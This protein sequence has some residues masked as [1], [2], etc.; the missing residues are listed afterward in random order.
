MTMGLE[1]STEKQR[2]HCQ[3][4]RQRRPLKRL[5]RRLSDRDLYSPICNSIEDDRRPPQL[6]AMTAFL[7]GDDGVVGNVGVPVR[8]YQLSRVR[9]S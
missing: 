9:G 7:S 5:H 1:R 3:Q 6:L 4:C 8:R 2:R